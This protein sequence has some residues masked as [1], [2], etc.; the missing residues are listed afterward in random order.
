MPIEITNLSL[1]EVEL[2]PKTYVGAASPIGIIETQ[3]CKRCNVN[4]INREVNTK[5][6]GFDKYL[7]EKLAHIQRK[8]RN[9]L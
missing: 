9:L 6:D 3:E 7:G 1:E 2:E 8:D 4:I 5:Q